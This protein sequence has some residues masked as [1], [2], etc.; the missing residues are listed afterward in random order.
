MSFDQSWAMALVVIALF[1]G[2]LVDFFAFVT[3]G[4]MVVVRRRQGHLPGKWMTKKVGFEFINGL[5]LAPLIVLLLSVFSTKLLHMLLEAS[6]LS[7]A[8]AAVCAI[9]AVV[10]EPE[11]TTVT[12]GEA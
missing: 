8:I 5:A 6:K 7:L 9:I 2:N 1:D 12:S 11:P 4:I 10:E 3:G